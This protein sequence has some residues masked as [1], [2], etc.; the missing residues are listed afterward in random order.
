MFIAFLG[1]AT[2]F[3]WVLPGFIRFL[4]CIQGFGLESTGFYWVLL[5]FVWFSSK[6]LLLSFVI[7]KLNGFYWVLPGFIRFL[8]LI[9]GFGLE[10]TGSYWVL[11][12][13]RLVFMGLDWVLSV[14]MRF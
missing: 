8:T 10:L 14:V 12:L 2:G 3:Y 6:L 4:T 9:K 7:C 11:C 13:F 5:G 1:L